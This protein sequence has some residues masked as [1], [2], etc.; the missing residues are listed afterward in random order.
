MGIKLVA[1]DPEEDSPAGQI[2]HKQVVG[3]F[4]D[5]EKIF[6]LA[7]HCDVLTVEIEHVNAD[8]MEEVA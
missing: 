2:C 5:A 8:A 4:K 1:L 3:D 7:S 6:E